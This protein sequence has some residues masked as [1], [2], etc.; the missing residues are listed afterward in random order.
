MPELKQIIPD[1]PEPAKLEPKQAQLRL[2]SSL[3]QF[4]IRAT[5]GRSWL[6]ILD[7]LQWADE[8]SVELLRYLGHHLGEISLL[9]VGT[10]RD[11]EVDSDHPL[12]T[13]LRDLGQMPAYRQ[14]PL[15]RLSQ[16]DVAQVLASLWQPGVPES[17][18]ET[19]YRHTE[20]NPLYVEEVAKGADG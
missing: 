11:T 17:L 19:I 10:Y 3:T 13:V 6:L 2:I 12:Q 1:L 8:S 4:I 16:A 18:T 15:D 20:G 14:L 5:Q 7:D 9:I